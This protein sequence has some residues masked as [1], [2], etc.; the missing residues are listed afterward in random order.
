MFRQLVFIALCAFFA[1]AWAVA[2]PNLKVDP[3][4]PDVADF[5]AAPV[6]YDRAPSA[7]YVIAPDGKHI[8]FFGYNRGYYVFDVAA[9]KTTAKFLNGPSYHDIS[10][11][12]D[13]KRIAT[14]E[15]WNGVS[16][17]DFKSGEV[18]STLK[19]TGELGVFYATFLPNGN[20]AGYCWKSHAGAGSQMTEQLAIW[21]TTKN[22]LIG[23]DTTD[24]VESREL[25]R[26]WFVGPDRHLLSM[27]WKTSERGVEVSR[28]CTLTDPVTN[29]E[30][31]KVVLEIDDF[32]CD[33]SPSGHTILVSNRK[34]NT[35][36][37]DVQSGKVTVE[38]KGHK[39]MVTCGAFSPA[40][41]HVV[42]ASGS[43]TRSNPSHWGTMKNMTELILWDV[44]TGKELAAVRDTKQ[45]KDLHQI[46]FSPDG[47]YVVAM[48]PAESPGKGHRHGGELLLW[49]KLPGRASDKSE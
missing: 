27:T 39:Q 34:G 32:V 47:K 44:A 4:S 46:K 29:K 35:R 33:A 13:G 21:D 42:T 8:I 1:N 23:W 3:R 22:K 14:A 10:F 19:P 24:R 17:R 7:E 26:R 43:R 28:S 37:I 45:I 48:T 40:G 25:T 11:S 12:S 38:L 2:A 30:S 49:G 36:L 31:N 16:I 41:R 20:L 9:G 15:W 6:T 18:L 5:K